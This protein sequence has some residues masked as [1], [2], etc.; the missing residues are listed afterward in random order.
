MVIRSRNQYA[1]NVAELSGTLSNK[2]F[3]NLSHYSHTM[4]Y[5][6]DNQRTGVMSA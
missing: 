6:M 3:L 4:T 2:S 1:A 5:A